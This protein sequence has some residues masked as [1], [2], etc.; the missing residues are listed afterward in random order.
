MYCNNCGRPVEPGA[1]FCDY[2]GAPLAAD[3]ASNRQTGWRDAALDGQQEAPRRQMPKLLLL[4][5]I[6]IPVLAAVVTL[7]VVVLKP[8][9][10][11]PA[12]TTLAAAETRAPVTDPPA[13]QALPVETAAPAIQSADTQPI[14]RENR[15]ELIIE[16]VD[17]AEA[18]AKA[19]TMGGHLATVNSPEEEAKLVALCSQHDR[20]HTVYLGGYLGTD[21]N[22][23]WITGEPFDQDFWFDTQPSYYD[24]DG[25]TLENVLCLYNVPSMGGWLWND[26]RDDLVSVYGEFNGHGRIAYLVEYEAN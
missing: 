20:I 7:L 1:R 9:D 5:L 21:W 24:D 19:E 4:A 14:L 25:V 8:D 12:E 22:F 23:H 11:A 6:W 2:C 18:K 16:D 3:P 17:W 26:C 15:Y 10:G 13:T